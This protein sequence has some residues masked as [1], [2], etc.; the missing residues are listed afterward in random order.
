MKKLKHVLLK[1]VL[2]IVFSAC[3]S[4]CSVDSAYDLSKDIDLTMAL[5]SDGLILKL[6]NTEKMYLRDIIKVGDSNMLDTLASGTTKSLYYLFKADSSN[7]NV[8]VNSIAPFQIKPIEVST[9]DLYTAPRNVSVNLTKD[10]TISVSSLMSFDITN[11]PSEVEEVHK[12]TFSNV[13]A[14]ITLSTS[15][16][17]FRLKSYSN[18]KIRFPSF[19]K[20]SS[21]IN[22]VYTAS[23]TSSTITIPIESVE[24]PVNGSFGQK[25]VNGQL[26]QSSDVGLNGDITIATNGT[27][28]LSSGETA[29]AKFNISVSQIS[30]QNMTGLVNPT[31][32]PTIAPIDISS[33]LPDFLKGNAV[34]LAISNP[35]IKFKIK[36]KNLPIPL[37]LKGK[38]NSV[39]N[40]AT[41]AS[42]SIPEAGTVSVSKNTTSSFYFSQ[43]GAPFDPSGVDASAASE[44]VRNLNSLVKTIPDKIQIDLSDEKITTDKTAEHSIGLGNTYGTDIDYEVLIPFQFDKGL[45]IVY[46]DSVVDMNNDL[47]DYQADGVTITATALNTIPLNLKLQITPCDVAGNEISTVSINSA[48]VASGSLDNPVRTDLN[49]TFTPSTAADISKIDKLMFKVSAS[50]SDMASGEALLSSQYIQLTNVRIKLNGRIVTNFN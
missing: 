29:S 36:G 25:V 21:F 42:V 48:T 30:P 24:L 18:L 23:G 35:T 17:K 6:G 12:I 8:K 7:V 50:A 34:Q 13:Y 4:A 46:N 41:I 37:L 27:V 49:V 15:N 39:K 14:T 1:F 32:S 33:D 28:N 26:S 19:V 5:G 2:A 44:I 47:K 31:I 38:I 9:G 11:I 10:T 22:Q 16:S 40:S 45:A 3:F 43:T 20:S